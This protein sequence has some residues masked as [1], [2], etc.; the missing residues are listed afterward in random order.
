MTGSARGKRIA[1]WAAW[2]TLALALASAAPTAAAEPEEGQLIKNPRQ[3]IFEGKRSGEGYFSRDG[4]QM[5]VASVKLDSIGF[6][7]FR[8]VAG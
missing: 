5:V 7:S 4:A 6:R 1:A 2:A 8:L 3:M